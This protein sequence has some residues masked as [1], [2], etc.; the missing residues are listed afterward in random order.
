MLHWSI[1]FLSIIGNIFTVTCDCVPP[2]AKPQVTFQNRIENGVP[3]PLPVH[4]FR[5]MAVYGL[6]GSEVLILL[7]NS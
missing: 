3:V 5:K 1:G 7:R 6:F 4:I 2:D